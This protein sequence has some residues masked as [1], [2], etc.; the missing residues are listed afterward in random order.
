MTIEELKS[1][2]AELQSKQADTAELKAQL[3]QKEQEI[4][5]LDRSV[6]AQQTEIEALK[7]QVKSNKKIS[8]KQ[9]IAAK[10]EEK[11]DDIDKFI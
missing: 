5:N 11:R 7:S 8:L 4:N 1:Q 2:L 3:E 6:K 9:A 10:L